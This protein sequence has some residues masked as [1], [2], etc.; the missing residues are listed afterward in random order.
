M[1]LTPILPEFLQGHCKNPVS[2][3]YHKSP[4]TGHHSACQHW[5]VPQMST[6]P[7]NVNISSQWAQCDQWE[8]NG[9]L[10]PS[11]LKSGHQVHSVIGQL[12]H[13]DHH[14][15]WYGTRNSEMVNEES[16]SIHVQILVAKSCTEWLIGECRQDRVEQHNLLMHEVAFFSIKQGLVWLCCYH[17]HWVFS[18]AHMKGILVGVW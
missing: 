1:V 16:T 9:H 6:F 18:R 14:L 15:G 12:Y 17:L 5:P 2:M 11:G 3:S 7:I 13:I 4:V 8:S 10:S